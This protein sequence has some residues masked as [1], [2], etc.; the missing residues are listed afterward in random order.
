VEFQIAAP[1]QARIEELAELANEGMIGDRERAEY[2]AFI[3]AADF[4]SILQ[5]KARVQLDSTVQ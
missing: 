3:N 2:E 1:V 5:L 4:I